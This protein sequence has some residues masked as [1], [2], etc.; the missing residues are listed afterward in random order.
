VRLVGMLLKLSMTSTLNHRSTTELDPHRGRLESKNIRNRMHRPQHQIML[1]H[2]IDSTLLKHKQ[3][4]SV[5]NK[6]FT[7]CN[8]HFLA[9]CINPFHPYSLLQPYVA[10]L[11]VSK[12]LYN[13]MQL[14]GVS[15]WPNIN[16]EMLWSNSF[17]TN[18]KVLF[19]VDIN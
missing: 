10:F 6:L 7:S 1:N 17:Q 18:N 19:K 16:V 3:N 2:I 11:C 9:L 14:L 13:I 15:N 12:D 5:C 4:C 8:C